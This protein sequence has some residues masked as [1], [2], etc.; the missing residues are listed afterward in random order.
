MF[1]LFLAC[2]ALL[3]TS[4][5]QG[6][7]TQWFD[8]D[9]PSGSG[10]WETLSDFLQQLPGEVCSV[11]TGVECRET[12]GNGLNVSQETVTCST[13]SGFICQNSNQPDGVCNDY[14]VRFLCDEDNVGCE[15]MDN[16]Y[17]VE[18][19][20]PCEDGI[21]D[22]GRYHVEPIVPGATYGPWDSD[23][24][25]VSNVGGGW[26]Y[27]RVD[28]N[29][30]GSFTLTVHA[31]CGGRNYSVSDVFMSYCGAT[32]QGQAPEKG[33]GSITSTLNR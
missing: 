9:N 10:D 23:Y 14:K 13:Q 19:R 11:P 18:Q 31:R 29:I 20:A 24:G 21:H 8:R 16:L 17:I 7:W 4:V 25:T 2:F 22:D 12:N 33:P 32:K 15:Q 1:R 3:L 26:T 30:F 6:D 5:A 28:T 27:V